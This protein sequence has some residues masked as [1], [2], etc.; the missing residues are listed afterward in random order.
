M[1]GGQPFFDRLAA[2]FYSRVDTDA[3]LRPL[4]PSDLGESTR[5]MAGFMAQYWGGSTDYSDERGHPRLRMRHAPFAIG[6]VERNAWVE[7][8]ERALDD[9]A[10][11]EP[12]VEV[13]MEYFENAATAMMNWDGEGPILDGRVRVI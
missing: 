8:M 12:V 11:P 5:F 7:Q 6:P 4:Y 3:R 9:V 2:A 10:P 1:V 13:M